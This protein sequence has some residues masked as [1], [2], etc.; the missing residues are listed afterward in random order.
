MRRCYA[1]VLEEAPWF[2]AVFSRDL[3][4]LA[5]A[6][7]SPVRY[8]RVSVDRALALWIDLETVAPGERLSIAD[9]GCNIGVI[10]QTLAAVAH[11]VTGIDNDLAGLVQPYYPPENGV[12]A[13]RVALRHGLDN[14][15]YRVQSI[16]DFAHGA[17][18][19]DVGLLLS[20]A[21]Q[22]WAG[23]AGTERGAKSIQQIYRLSEEICGRFERYLYLEH[24]AS[25]DGL[26]KS[27][28]AHSFLGYPDWFR[29]AGLAKTVLPI[30]LSPDA[31]GN[32]RTLYRITLR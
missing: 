5:D 3:E 15:V 22:W 16:E 19:Y 26:R 32:L 29:E 25:L 20:V 27:I 28:D 13:R 23:Y 9:L 12:I 31:E 4:R 8:D 10:G 11:T 7:D 17:D 24:P 14:F 6:I 18:R 30:A 2:P 1:P 21:H